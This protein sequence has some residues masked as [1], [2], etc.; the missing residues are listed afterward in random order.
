[1][2]DRLAFDQSL[3]DTARASGASVVFGSRVEDVSIGGTAATLRFRN[4]GEVRCRVV[5]LACGASY[6]L[7]RRLGLG[8]PPVYLQ[9]AQLEVPAGRAGDVEVYFGR[10][11]APN[12]FAW[13]VPVRRR[14]ASFARIGLMCDRDSGQYFRRF[15]RRLA[16]VWQIDESAITEP[17]QKLLPLAPIPRTSAD[18]V[19]VVGD[20]AGIVKATTGGGIYY[21]VLSAT[22]A[23]STLVHA[24]RRKT[25]DA[26][27][28]ARYDRAWQQRLGPEIRAQLQLRELAHRL[29][30]HDIEAFFDLARTDGVMPIVRETARFNQHR[31][32]IMA[33][34]RHP[35]A[36]RILL[37]RLR[38]R[39]PGHRDASL[40][41]TTT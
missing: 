39:W 32:L 13:A 18:R 10:E 33:L 38:G 11:V 9:S 35:P 28:L 27:T 19:V 5:V 36:R 34:L 2:V 29:D 41:Q 30:D 8:M 22:L 37:G 17:R 1:V 12:G 21:S 3:F 20:A 26:G 14:H 31:A 6:V 4:G 7:Q 15:A 16:G 23:A 25:F 40:E 24:F